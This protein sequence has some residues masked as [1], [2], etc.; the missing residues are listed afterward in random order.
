MLTKPFFRCPA[1]L[2]PAF[3]IVLM[4]SCLLGACAMT[5]LRNQSATQE[6]RIYIAPIAEREGQLLRGYL[7]QEQG[8]NADKS[9]TLQLEIGLTQTAQRLQADYRLIDRARKLVL[10]DESQ[11]LEF[12]YSN[13][14]Q[15]NYNDLKQKNIQQKSLP[16]LAQRIMLRVRAVLVK[17]TPYS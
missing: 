17:T 12:A 4:L 3:L 11:Q 14:P 9:A 6:A 2:F 8:G 13:L 7:V 5:P 16:V 10:L 1:A 15:S